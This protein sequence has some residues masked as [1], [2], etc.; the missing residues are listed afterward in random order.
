MAF[1]ILSPDGSESLDKAFCLHVHLFA[2]LQSIIFLLLSL[3][4]PLA[5]PNFLCL[6]FGLCSSIIPGKKRKE[7][8]SP[9]SS[10]TSS[11]VWSFCTFRLCKKKVRS[12]ADTARVRGM[13]ALQS[14]EQRNSSICKNMMYVLIV[15]HIMTRI[16]FTD[17][18]PFRAPT[19]VDKCHLYFP[20][21]PSW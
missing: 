4:L 7:R 13:Q 19:R 17:L 5:S 18:I 21:L 16:S 3:G 20:V 12:R 14:L 9:D 8:L 10:W 6:H 2:Y 11:F 15:R 1:S